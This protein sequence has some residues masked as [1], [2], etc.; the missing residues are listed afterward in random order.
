MMAALS[1]FDALL[2][3]SL[4]RATHGYPYGSTPR[5][6][7]AWTSDDFIAALTMVI[8][9]FMAFL[10]LL[11]IKLLLGMVLLQYSRKRYAAMKQTESLVASG[12]A[13]LES[14]DANGRRV[15]GRAEVEVG[16]ERQRWIH[17]DKSEGLKGKKNKDGAYMGA[18]RYEM[19][20]KRIW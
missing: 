14:Y 18:A 15:G 13:E 2:R 12:K 16:E 20:A 1:R 8:V 5:P 19:V 4:G 7:Y 6:W 10:V 9:F 17:A 11:M 3:D